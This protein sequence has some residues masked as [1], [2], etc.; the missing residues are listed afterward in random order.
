MDNKERERELNIQLLKLELMFM[1]INDA[2]RKT[3]EPESD[4]SIPGNGQ[5][6][7][8]GDDAGNDAPTTD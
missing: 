1:E 5:P 4:L 6:G 3:S 2:E 7:E 8:S